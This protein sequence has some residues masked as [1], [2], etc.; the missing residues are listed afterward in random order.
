MQYLPILFG[1]YLVLDEQRRRGPFPA[2]PLPLSGASKV[3]C[4][5]R[6]KSRATASFAVNGVGGDVLFY[7]YPL[8]LI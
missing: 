5:W 8:R 7:M 2:A 3:G 6:G 4:L 1:S